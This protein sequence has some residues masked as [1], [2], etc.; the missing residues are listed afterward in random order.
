MSPRF[1]CSPG[2]IKRAVEH[3]EEGRGWHATFTVRLSH[4]LQEGD[5]KQLDGDYTFTGTME[6]Y[7]FFG[8]RDSLL[9]L[10]Y[11]LRAD[12]GRLHAV[13]YLCLSDGNFLDEP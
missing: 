5:V 4:F 6:G 7:A 13:P 2:G 8:P 1:I 10:V 9:S 3:L 11:L 12:D